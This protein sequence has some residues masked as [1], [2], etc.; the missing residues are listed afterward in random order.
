MLKDEFD[1]R[2]EAAQPENN[3]TAMMVRQCSIG[4][5]LYIYTVKRSEKV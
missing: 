3:N 5:N 2:V 4:W 1:R